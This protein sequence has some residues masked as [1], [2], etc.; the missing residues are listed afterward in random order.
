MT[1]QISTKEDIKRLGTILGVWAHPDDEVMAMCGILCAAVDNGQTVVCITAT[2]GEAGVQDEAR[3][4]AQKLA[5]IRTQ[6]LKTAYDL[7]GVK[8]HHWLDYPDGG[9]A[10]VDDNQAV[11]R[12]VSL[13]E[14]Y[15]P[16]SIL[17][18]GPDGMTGHPDHQ[19]V[20][21]W[22]GLASRADGMP[23]LYHSV[24]TEEQLAAM[25]R[26]DEHFNFF[27]NVDK[28]KTCIAN[29]CDVLLA[30]DDEQIAC[31]MACLRSMPSQYEAVLATFGDALQRGLSTEAFVVAQDVAV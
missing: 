30:L 22:A 14:T 11:Q 26:A 29:D 25:R 23:K 18:F 6:E 1:T 13:I 19:A 20:S 28:P 12:L 24:L 3:W 27:F 5:D 8:Y 31:K 15:R 17:T 9:C 10:E 2:R 4:P 21:R 16:D 7:I